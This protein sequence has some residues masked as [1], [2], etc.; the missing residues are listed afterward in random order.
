MLEP[1]T[2]QP[3]RP[4]SFSFNSPLFKLLLGLL[5]SFLLV[6]IA[7]TRHEA[8]HAL[9]IEERVTVVLAT[10][11]L[12][13]LGAHLLGGA[14]NQLTKLAHIVG[15][16]FF[17]LLLGNLPGVGHRVHDLFHDPRYELETAIEW[18]SQIAVWL[19][20][21]EA[22]LETELKSLAK[23]AGRATLIALVGVIIPGAI[24]YAM[25][26][27]LYPEL[28]APGRLLV[29]SMFTPTSLGVA[30]IFFKSFGIV[31]AMVAQL[32]MAV[33]AIDDI[34][35]LLLLTTLNG[36]IGGQPLA[37]GNVALILSKAIF[38]FVCAFV[39]GHI[40]SP[41]L[42]R[43]FAKLNDSE[44][45][46]LKLA[47]SSTSIL[48]FLAW[49]WGLSPLMGAYAGGVFLTS[50]HFKAF[51]SDVEE[52][53]VEY[54]LKGLRYT[55]VPIFIVSVAMKADL[56]VLL[57]PRPTLLLIGG[58]LGL[59]AGK[60]LAARFGGPG[61]DAG[62]LLWGAL[63]RGEVALV[64]ASMGYSAHLFGRDIL[65]VAVLTMLL[66]I[67]CTSIFLPRAIDRAKARDPE[68]FRS[69]GSP[70]HEHDA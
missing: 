42:S 62:T 68:A 18:T 21:A 26:L 65:S 1:S 27:P 50:V 70:A 22:G 6:A 3:S 54:L 10:V 7:M 23:N 34:I 12:L 17:G 16:T 44:A 67:V 45:M 28:S 9:S 43:L 46:R 30:S 4:S 5:C 48:S 58:T 15:W 13:S 57:Q 53:G 41:H 2:D 11:S 61:N 40:L 69:V 59:I 24:A 35:G 47:L 37:L 8:Q 25:L 38:F 20:L 66:T 52:H 33:A 55:I 51:A 63:P 60:W 56:S 49:K 32:V 36:V 14:L 29:A 31:A 64:I 39:A 19:L